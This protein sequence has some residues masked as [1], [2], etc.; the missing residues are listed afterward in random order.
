LKQKAN[1]KGKKKHRKVKI[2]SELVTSR[3]AG[4][5]RDAER[6]E[7]EEKEKKKAQSQA[8][9]AARAG[10]VQ[11][12]RAEMQ[13]DPTHAFSGTLASKNKTE[14]G[15]ILIALGLSVDGKKDD[16]RQRLEDH[17]K[18]FPDLK[19]NARYAGLFARRTRRPHTATSTV[20]QPND[21][22]ASG[23]GMVHPQPV[24]PL[25]QF[26][27]WPQPQ[28]LPETGPS[29]MHE[30]TDTQHH[31]SQFPTATF[32]NQFNSDHRPYNQVCYPQY[33]FNT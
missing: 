32:P 6:L 4:A 27:P 18:M 23:S 2:N 5:R 10:A 8:V 7:R 24:Q 13:Q 9:K 3:E 25:H 30:A 16:L 28:H 29:R 14:L 19:N 11:A 17:F 1:G 22:S 26:Q 20:E 31:P 33:N 21:N 15:D 12:R